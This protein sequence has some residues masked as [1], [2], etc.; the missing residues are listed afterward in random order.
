MGNFSFSSQIRKKSNN[1]N[2]LTSLDNDILF[3]E[4]KFKTVYDNHPDAIFI[5]DVNGKIQNYNQ[6]MKNISGYTDRALQDD[7][8]R[9]FD[10]ESK[11]LSNNHFQLALKGEAQNFQA[12]VSH[13][14]GRLIPVDITY[15]PIMNEDMQVIGVYGI[16]KD[17]TMSKMVEKKLRESEQRF[18]HIYDN[19]SL[20]IRS[21]DVQKKEVIMASLGMEGVT[22]YAP[23]YFHQKHS[24]E[25]IIHP[26]DYS[27]YQTEY[28]KLAD[29]KS[30]ILQYRIIHKNGETVWVQ[31]KTL[32][33]FDAEGNFI[34]VDGIVSNISDQKEY[35]N[36]IKHLAYYDGL[37][38]LPN[39]KIFKR[40]IE[41]LMK[42]VGGKKD[43]F[44][45]MIMDLDRFK[46]INQTLGHEMGD[47]LLQQF[48]KRISHLLNKTSLFSRNDGD[49]FGIVIWDYEPS[50]Y[51]GTLAKTIIDSLKK[52]FMID[53]FELYLT[54]SIGICT[55]PSNGTS[56][57]E[58]V[59]H[60][61]ATLY[62]AKTSG[63]NNYQIYSS[64]FNI[65]SY[66]QFDIEKDLRK[67]IE[68]KQLLLHFQP[69]V[70][71]LTGKIVSAE[72]LIRWE[73]PVWGLVS[74]GE[75]IPLAEET[76]FINEISDWVLRQVCHYISDWQKQKLPIVPISM[77][78]TA[79]RFLRSNWK[80]TLLH[81]LDETN[82]DPTLIEIEITETTLIQ[83]EKVVESAL[84]FLKEHGIKIALDDFGT[85]YSSLSYL[86]D[87][88]ID[89]IKIDRSFVE[90]ISRT[91][92]VEIIIKALI[93][94]AKGLNMNIVAEGVETIEQLDFLKQQE[95]H[96]IQGYLFSKPVSLETFQSLLK[97]VILKP[98][99]SSEKPKRQERR[100][101]FRVNI[102]SPMSSQ[103]TLTS[104]QGKQ[105]EL[106]KTEVLI[107]DIGPGGLKFLSTIQLPIRPDIQFQFETT[108]MD[109]PVKLQGHVVWKNEVKGIFQYGVHFIIDEDERS[110]LIKILYN[111]LLQLKKNPFV[112]NCGFIKEDR[113]LY[114][115]KMNIAI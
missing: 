67:A 109:Q 107:E 40:K 92:D 73:H 76:G 35:E 87:L 17:I 102:L 23:E 111:F 8:K 41:S 86:K 2:D 33:V 15:A 44:S 94:M 68:N 12:A 80:S 9:N 60:A 48:A 3:N 1:T 7:F 83:H 114:L 4:K 26:D 56:L 96:E 104:I 112:P 29:G 90:Q 59:K 70:D 110:S 88:S 31:D 42:L 52:P 36:K 19:L 45:I 78:V 64:S 22:G 71:A 81:I 72:A 108:I 14:N 30:F 65:T 43:S 51:P 47:K 74:P 100:N 63:K 85:G 46:N 53:D 16:G 69:R 58:M 91:T 54:A 50:T 6:S 106:G 21:V 49:E 55:N 103:M 77:N 20:G 84:Q 5:V 18:E 62:R 24:W 105:V 57:S 61:D 37:T 115:K 101:Y 95:C 32:P 11:S 28:S 38:N 97:K 66:K 113:F 10:E 98:I 82:I 79:Q 39:R 99:D 25:S 93:F 89:T 75:F 27:N 13:K 34:R